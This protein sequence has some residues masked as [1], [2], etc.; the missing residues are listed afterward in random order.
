MF[1]C[2]GRYGYEQRWRS[3]ENSRVVR[4]FTSVSDMNDA[5]FVIKDNN[6]FEYY[7]SLYDSVKNTRFGGTYKRAGDTLLL[8]FFNG[9]G[10]EWLGEK[11]ILL[12][13]NQVLFPEAAPEARMLHLFN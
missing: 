1:S 6:Y 3:L 11:A 12:N 2:Q 4:T 9:R 8:D 7:K 5:H 13:G 10:K